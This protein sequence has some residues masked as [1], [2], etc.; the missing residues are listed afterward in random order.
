MSFFRKILLFIALFFFSLLQTLPP[1]QSIGAHDS[2]LITA[3][4]DIACDPSTV[5]F[6]NP[7]Q[8]KTPDCQMKATAD[9]IEQIDVL[10][11]LPLGDTQYSR[12]AFA[13]FQKSYAPTWGR[14]KKISHP[15]PG[16]HE[17]ET[18]GAAGYYQYFGA[19]AGDPKKGYYSVDLGNWHLIALNSNCESVGGCEAGSPQEQWLKNDL[20]TH[21]KACTLAYWHHPRY[22]SGFHGSDARFDDFWKDLYQAGVELVLTGHDHDYERFAPQAPGGKADRE[23][24]VREF[25][26]GTGGASH[27]AFQETQPHSEVRHTGTFGV[28]QLSLLPKAYQWKFVPVAG[29]SFTDSGT[30]TCH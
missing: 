12:G 22:S 16:N 28:L 29:K 5:S 19:A 11:V 18:E 21:P 17:Y 8:V 26:V 14:L 24:G 9:L 20:A 15:V 10:A 2:L 4:G 25:V 30:D 13:A 3:A 27:Y 23:K 6:I 1:V 7:G